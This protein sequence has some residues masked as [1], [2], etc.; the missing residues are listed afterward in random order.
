MENENA[1]MQ[2]LA[3]ALVALMEPE[4]E[5]R[6][7]NYGDTLESE[8]VSEIESQMESQMESTLPAEVED[9]MLSQF[10]DRMVEAVENWLTDRQEHLIVPEHVIEKAVADALPKV[11]RGAVADLFSPLMSIREDGTLVFS[12]STNTSNWGA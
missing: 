4:I 11:V 12:L 7:Q 2:Q 1:F 9:Q 10:D 6:F 3:S 5:K 8:I